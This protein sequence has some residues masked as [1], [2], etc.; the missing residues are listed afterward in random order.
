MRLPLLALLLTLAPLR[1]ENATR[2][3]A[4]LLDD[5]IR[6]GGYNQTCSA[7]EL[8]EADVPISLYWLR[9]KPA[10]IPS[11]E[12]FATLLAR[13]ADVVAA[14]ASI[15]DKMDVA[16][17]AAPQKKQSDGK[18]HEWDPIADFDSQQLSVALLNVVMRLSAADALPGMLKVE[19]QLVAII[20]AAE[21]DAA[22]P[23]PR[24]EVDGVG[25]PESL[26]ESEYVTDKAG[27]SEWKRKANAK[28][29]EHNQAIYKCRF[30]QR[31]LLSLM[32]KFLRDARFQPLLDSA[33]ERLYGDVLKAS[34]KSDELKGYKK[35]D[36]I[37]EKDRQ[38]IR[39]DSI[40]NVPTL[41]SKSKDETPYT[42]E[43]RA[44][45]RGFVSQFLTEHPAK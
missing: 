41:S 34:A 43:L 42:P 31:E 5:A 12:S 8:V 37:P 25:Y 35:P 20:E 22:A 11:E 32:A 14:L 7:D 28:E 1:A 33:F 23:V 16:K 6:N 21:R 2:T 27:K 4:R 38:W 36:D 10:F 19:A 17:P 30:Y 40:Y 13:R 44:Q 29:I 15:F 3:G 18:K 45:I 9:A 26:R 24:L 39:W